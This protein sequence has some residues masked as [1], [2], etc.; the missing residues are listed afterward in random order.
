MWLMSFGCDVRWNGWHHPLLLRSNGRP[1]TCAGPRLL[2]HG[3]RG[4]RCVRIVRIAPLSTSHAAL[5]RFRCR[6]GGLRPCARHLC[7]L[8]VV[9]LRGLLR[10]RLRGLIPR[11]YLVRLSGNIPSRHRGTRIV[12]I[13]FGVSML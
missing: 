4:C 1:A 9:L 6:R 2:C 3:I 12:V 8:V 7:N 5:A 11:L 13:R 10:G